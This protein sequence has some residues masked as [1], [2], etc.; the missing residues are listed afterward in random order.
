MR[1]LAR[2]SAAYRMV[3]QY[4]DTPDGL[5]LS[6][7]ACPIEGDLI[8][9]CTQGSWGLSFQGWHNITLM[10]DYDTVEQ[11]LEMQGYVEY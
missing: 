1:K 5:K 2:G 6:I 7:Y 10:Q 3:Q 11:A 4:H 9:I 8:H